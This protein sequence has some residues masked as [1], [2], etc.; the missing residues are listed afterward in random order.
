MYEEMEKL[1]KRSVVVSPIG[2]KG[3]RMFPV[4]IVDGIRRR[5]GD[6][7]LDELYT[8]KPLVRVRGKELILWFVEDYKRFG[9]K[10]FLFLV[11][12]GGEV[13]KEFLGDGSK[14]GIEARYHDDPPAEKVGKGKALKYAFE[15]NVLSD[16]DEVMWWGFPDDIITYPFHVAE[17]AMRFLYFRKKY[18]VIGVLTFVPQAK[19]P[20]GTAEV[21]ENGLIKQFEEKPNVKKP[22]STGRGVFVIDEL[23]P[24]VERYIDINRPGSVE[25][26]DAV[27]P[28]LKGKLAAYMLPDCDNW[29]PINSLKDLKRAEEMLYKLV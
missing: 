15:R 1:K 18:E 2:G 28:R 5:Y 19:F 23:R 13:V 20:Y 17:L 27:F 8:P 6:E 11:G 21:D 25:I 29:I 9:V 24:W 22:T 7:K 3:S 16:G 4:E 14:Y 10:K 12:K 26:E